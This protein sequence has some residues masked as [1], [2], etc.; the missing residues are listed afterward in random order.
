LGTF[1]ILVALAL[2]IGATLLRKREESKRIRFGLVI[3][4]LA[5][6]GIGLTIR[7][8]TS[9]PDLQ[10]YEELAGYRLGKVL[11][12]RVDGGGP[13]LVLRSPTDLQSEEP[14]AGRCRGLRSAC[15][16]YTV[17]EA[18]P[19]PLELGPP[20][21]DFQILEGENW[22]EEVVPWCG[23]YPNAVAVVSLL[24]EFPPLATVWDQDLP[25]LYGFAT[26]PSLAW[27]H[28]MRAGQL[29]A[30]VRYKT[31]AG[32]PSL[33]PRGATPEQAFD[34]HFELVTPETLEDVLGNEL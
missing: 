34:H 23:Q 33:P 11:L 25:L 26:G 20:S 16:G 9:E 10:E 13:I 27:A 18:G 3:A 28:A 7:S 8:S 2:T 15:S 24:F 19:D 21:D 1:L 17:I 12:D 14:T 29:Q 32:A 5:A 31:V 22:T 30:V 6:F 4:A